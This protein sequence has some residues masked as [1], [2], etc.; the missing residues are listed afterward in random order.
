MVDLANKV[1]V[2]TGAANGLGKALATALYSEGCHLALIDI[3]NAG[4]LRLQADLGGNAR[5]VSI[6]ITDI[7]SEE[8]IAAARA[9]ILQQHGRIDLLVN[10]A[11][12]S[13]SQP[14]EELELD[15]FRGLFKTN[16][17]GTV[18]CIRYFLP[19][20]KKHKGSLLVNIISGFATMGFP[21]KTA[22]ASSKSA[23]MGFSNCLKTELEGTNVS[24]SL[25]IPPPLHT[26]IVDKGKH[27]SAL[28]KERE[29]AFLEKNAM[30]ADKAA[31]IIV[32][33]LKR[34]RYRIVAG[35]RTYW[36]DLLAR[37]FP[38][39]VHHLI[40]KNKKRLDFV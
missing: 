17:W 38:G 16:F 39:M 24:I 13:I 3:D 36:L 30:P 26:T 29:T 1:A 9:A 35:T 21:A 22:Y 25:M 28:K 15:D 32:A 18:Y 14:F 12:V 11:A 20:L 31:R 23:V 10:N 40:A 4:L 6:H 5:Q 7:S 8:Q 33:K 27:I 2:I 34:G 37:S 19:D